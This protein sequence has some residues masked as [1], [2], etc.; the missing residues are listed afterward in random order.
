MENITLVVF[1]RYPTIWRSVVSVEQTVCEGSSMKPHRGRLALEAIQLTA[2]NGCFFIHTHSHNS[3][4]VIIEYSIKIHALT[5]IY[6]DIK[7]GST[8][9]YGINNANKS[10]RG[11]SLIHNFFV[12]T[13]I[14]IFMNI[15]INKRMNVSIP[16][17]PPF[18]FP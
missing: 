9:Q 18:T 3:N 8:Q 15:L 16:A 14:H 1:V 7:Y 6:T 5:A 10:H 11:I 12:N 17:P 2:C 4:F 13:V